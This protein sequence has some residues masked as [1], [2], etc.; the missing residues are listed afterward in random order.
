MKRQKRDR[1]SRA[2]DKGYQAGL[3]H[4]SRDLCPFDELQTRASW[5]NGWRE[6]YTHHVNGMT[7]VA[8]IQNLRNLG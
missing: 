7:G 1:V 5:L 8:S 2:F 6:G 3:N 4:R